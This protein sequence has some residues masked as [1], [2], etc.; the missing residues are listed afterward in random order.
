M[1]E[2]ETQPQQT[3]AEWFLD[4]YANTNVA[5]HHDDPGDDSAYD[6]MSPTMSEAETTETSSPYGPYVRTGRG[7]AGNFQWQSRQKTDLEAQKPI[8]LKEKRKA[9]LNIEHIDTS[10]AVRNAQARKGSQYVRMGRGGAGNMGYIQSNEPQPSPT[11]LTFT[12]SPV[13]TTSPV[14]A[15]GRGGAGNFAVARSVSAQATLEK[16][17]QE[18]AEAEKRRELAEQQVQSMLQAPSQA[19]VGTRRRSGLPDDI[20]EAQTWS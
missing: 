6:S 14:F 3:W 12:K 11:A 10:A 17:K 9:A 15:S 1:V 13:S 20:T 19:Y 8:G 4:A 7:G 18:R 2:S 5:S 16:E